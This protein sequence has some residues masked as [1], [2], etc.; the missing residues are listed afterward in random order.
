MAT[1]RYMVWSLMSV[2]I[3]IPME[4]QL[5]GEKV[6]DKGKTD[7]SVFH[8]LSV[9]NHDFSRS[10]SCPDTYVTKG[11]NLC[12]YLLDATKFS[13]SKTLKICLEF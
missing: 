5:S 12:Y 6:K 10:V 3:H 11:K 2:S 1:T 7:Y 8:L 13:L 4:G 9:S